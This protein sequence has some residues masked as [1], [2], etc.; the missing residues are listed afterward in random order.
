[1]AKGI[2]E[3]IRNVLYSYEDQLTFKSEKELVLMLNSEMENK[4]SIEKD[5][6]EKNITLSKINERIK[7]LNKVI[8]K[9]H[10]DSI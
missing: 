2:I 10:L 9:R 7:I 4:E 3:Q 6:D 8:S 1:M 5:I